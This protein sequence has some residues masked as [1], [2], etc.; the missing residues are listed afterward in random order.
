MIARAREDHDFHGSR[1]TLV[2]VTDV[3]F[4]VTSE[5][6]AFPLSLFL[7]LLLLEKQLMRPSEPVDVSTVTSK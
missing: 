4:T 3:S 7:S 6:E 5:S 1:A 2:E